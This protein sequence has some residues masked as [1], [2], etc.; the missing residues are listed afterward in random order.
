MHTLVYHSTAN[1]D[2]TAKDVSNISETARVFN[3]KM[4]FQDVLFI[5]IIGLFRYW[6][7]T[8]QY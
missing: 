7:V 1:L 3:K 4:V 6:K 2:L 5:T 8:K